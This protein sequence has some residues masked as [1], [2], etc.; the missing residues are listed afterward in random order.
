M[1]NLSLRSC[2][3]FKDILLPD[4]KLLWMLLHFLELWRNLYLQVFNLLYKMRVTLFKWLNVVGSMRAI[5]DTL[6]ADWVASAGKTIIANELIGMRIT[7]GLVIQ[8]NWRGRNRVRWSQILVSSW[9]W[10]LV[11]VSSG[12]MVIIRVG[13]WLVLLPIG[14]LQMHIRYFECLLY[15]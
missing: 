3:L 7:K 12:A 11:I 10:C 8:S 15:E 14:H 6:R 1:L 5:N 4:L 9:S 13:F 2:I